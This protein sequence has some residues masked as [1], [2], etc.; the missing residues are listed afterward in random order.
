MK[1]CSYSGDEML[2]AGKVA[3]SLQFA[4]NVVELADRVLHELTDGGKRSFNGLHLRLES[5]AMP[6][7][8]K[9][10]GLEVCS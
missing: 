4:P 3:Q 5:D 1:I 2:L 8:N 9:I 6:W 7:V 10:G